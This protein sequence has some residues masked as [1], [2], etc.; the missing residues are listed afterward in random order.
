MRDMFLNVLEEAS[1]GATLWVLCILEE[2]APLA[3]EAPHNRQGIE[4]RLLHHESAPFG[5]DQ[6]LNNLS[7]LSW[8]GWPRASSGGQ[9]VVLIS[10]V[11]FACTPDGPCPGYP[12]WSTGVCLMRARSSHVPIDHCIYFRGPLVMTH[13]HAH[14]AEPNDRPDGP[15]P[16]RFLP[17]RAIIGSSLVSFLDACRMPCQQRQDRAIATCLLTCAPTLLVLW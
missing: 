12:L 11:V 2:V 3:A 16:C 5:G 13:D 15:C 14:L 10:P 9:Y 4:R 8:V 7:F 17:W 6:G 1:P